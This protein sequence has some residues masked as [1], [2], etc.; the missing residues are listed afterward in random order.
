VLGV[1]FT[2]LTLLSKPREAS[3]RGLARPFSGFGRGGHDNDW[4]RQSGLS[5]R[6]LSRL[7]FPDLGQPVREQSLQLGAG[8]A[9]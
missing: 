5:P 8:A 3:I 6:Y 1:C 4:Y 7:R 9:A 2:Y